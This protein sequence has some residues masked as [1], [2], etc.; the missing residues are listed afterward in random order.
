MIVIRD[1][2]SVLVYAHDRGI[3]HLHRR[4]MTGSQRIR[5]PVPAALRIFVHHPKKTFA[6]IS[7]G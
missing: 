4:V 3:N 1:I 2:G 5:D 7:A 6:T